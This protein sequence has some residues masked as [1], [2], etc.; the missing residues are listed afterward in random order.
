MRLAFPWQPWGMGIGDHLLRAMVIEP[1]RRT[2]RADELLIYAPTAGGQ[3]LRNWPGSTF[4]REWDS[5]YLDICAATG[6]PEFLKPLFQRLELDW[7]DKRF[8]YFPTAHESAFAERW[9]G[10]ARN[11]VLIQVQGGMANKRY[12]KWHEVAREL[13]GKGCSV[14]FL[15]GTMQMRKSLAAVSACDVFIGFDSGP[16][17]A[18]LG[19]WKPSVAIFPNDSPERLFHPIRGPRYYA[20]ICRDPDAVPPLR[21]VD[22]AM[23]ALCA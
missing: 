23:E 21:L 4:T 5:S 8:Y 3:S 12:S 1:Y 16:F 20:H 7:V 13:E 2:G 15:A 6:S 10:P 14:R 17:Y 9:W 11:R 19:S 22:D 18:A